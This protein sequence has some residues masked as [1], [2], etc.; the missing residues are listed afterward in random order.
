[1]A[2]SLTRNCLII[3]FARHAHLERIITEAKVRCDNI[4]I[5]QNQS[6]PEFENDCDKVRRIIE[7]HQAENVITFTPPAHLPS[8]QSIIYA[9]T[10]FFSKVPHGTILEDDCLPSHQLWDALDIFD[11]T[12]CDA[13]EFVMNGFTPVGHTD[14]V[15]LIAKQPYLH[16]W[17]WSS[18]STTWNNFITQYSQPLCATSTIIQQKLGL[19][20]TLYWILIFNM[21]KTN[22]IKSWDY[23]FLYYLWS[24]RVPIFGVSA[25]LVQNMGADEFSQFMVKDK[26]NVKLNKVANTIQSFKVEM[27]DAVKSPKQTNQQHY[28]ICWWRILILFMI[29]VK[30]II[31][32]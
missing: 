31:I 32:K 9:I 2:Q 19:K 29:N 1:M 6:S 16:V 10:H 30:S 5:Y 17:G 7:S 4:Y 24:N 13:S 22:K 20:A 25:N 18:N 15:C 3:T 11:S 27:T 28:Q 23:H 12:N 8:A 26:A 21:V 14:S